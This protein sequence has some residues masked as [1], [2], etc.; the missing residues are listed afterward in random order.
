MD[1]KS[2]VKNINVANFQ[3][4]MSP[5]EI[6][7]RYTYSDTISKNIVK[8]RN[9]IKD[10]ISHRSDK[11]LCVIGPCSIHNI[12]E[13]YEYAKM[14]YKLHVK[15][16]DKLFI[17]MRVYFEKPRTTVGWKGLINDPYLNNTYDINEG[18]NLA[19]KLL[20]NINELGLPCACEMLDP[21]TTQYIDDL[22][23]WAAIGARTTESQTHRQMVSG[24]S[25]P[26]GFKNSTSGDV[27]PAIDGVSCARNKHVF[28]GINDEGQ[29][30]LVHTKGNPHCHII[31]RGGKDGPNYD[32]L[33]ID[34]IYSKFNYDKIMIDCSHG[35]SLK[36]FRNQSI[37]LIN[38]SKQIK[39][40]RSKGN[41]KIMGIMLESNIN[42]GKQ[43]LCVENGAVKP[44]KYGVSVTDCCI[45]FMETEE[46]IKT[47]YDLL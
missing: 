27:K 31:L 46:L 45:S 34:D 16:Y 1:K 26:V 28:L 6:K 32:S 41:K 11:L 23:S 47:L 20:I 39:E 10:I 43:T 12:D 5:N 38:I 42:E 4:I 2:S 19:R 36:N 24:L 8:F 40:E 7:N 44:L 21:I 29:S 14:L 22:V 3:T 13:A 37:V 25:M 15:F 9:E 35:N 17:I 18:L 30:C 33:I